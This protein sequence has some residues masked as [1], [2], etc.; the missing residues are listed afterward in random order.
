MPKVRLALIDDH[1]IVRDGLKALLSKLEHCEV[2]A[3]GGCGEDAVELARNPAIEIFLMDIAMPGM[4][5]ID[6]ARR[7]CEVRPDAR[8]IMLSMHASGEYVRRAMDSGASGYMLKNMAPSE[9]DKAINKVAN[10]GRYLS[11][12]I[13]GSLTEAQSGD[14]S[15]SELDS[16]SGRQREILRLLAEGTSTR[17][18]AEMLSISAKTVE[19]HRSQLMQKL[20]IYDVPGLVRF[21]VRHGL[22]SVE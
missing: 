15:S 9:L 13:A 7:I 11:P 6:A 22:V 14:S 4:S 21:A 12:A 19:S 5:G 16:L 10:G 3:E 8:I 18:I 17:D 1:Q 2:I 20:D